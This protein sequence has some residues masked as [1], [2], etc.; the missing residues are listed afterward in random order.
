MVLRRSQQCVAIQV[1]IPENAVHKSK[2]EVL[3]ALGAQVKQSHY[4]SWLMSERQIKK[5][6]IPGDIS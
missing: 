3:K 6:A 4:S 2:V 5:V 1:G